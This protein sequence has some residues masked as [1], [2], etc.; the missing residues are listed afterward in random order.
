MHSSRMRAARSLPYR[1]TPLY[2]HPPA[3]VDRQTPVKTLPSQTS[4]AGG[5][6]SKWGCHFYTFTSKALVFTSECDR[7]GLSPPRKS[8]VSVCR[9]QFTECKFCLAISANT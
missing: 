9:W 8:E 4:F 2:R 5:N 6:D 1:E 3:P 7:T